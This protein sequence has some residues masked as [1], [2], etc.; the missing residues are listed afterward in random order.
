MNILQKSDINRQ[1]KNYVKIIDLTYRTNRYNV[2]LIL[3]ILILIILK[4]DKVVIFSFTYKTNIK[5]TKKET[6]FIFQRTSVS[7]TIAIIKIN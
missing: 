1:P 5:D 3:M 7:K 4:P 6:H 2:M